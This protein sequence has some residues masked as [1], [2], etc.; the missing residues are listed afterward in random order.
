M[1]TEDQEHYHSVNSDSEGD[2]GD[3]AFTWSFERFF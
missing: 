3:A 1:Q 2:Y